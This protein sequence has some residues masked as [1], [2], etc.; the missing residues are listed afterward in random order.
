MVDGR[1]CGLARLP[2]E[3]EPPGCV[4]IHDGQEHKRSMQGPD[5][6]AQDQPPP[7]AHIR[8]ATHGR[9]IQLGQ[10]RKSGCPAARSALA[11]ANG[12]RETLSACRK[13]A[14]QSAAIVRKRLSTAARR[15]CLNVFKSLSNA[16][17]ARRLARRILSEGSKKAADDGLRRTEGRKLRR[18]LRLR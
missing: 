6:D 4:A 18:G 10:R 17:S 9:S 13:S 12:H 11:P 5:T 2:L 15:R 1:R 14:G 8:L 3:G 7:F 16:R